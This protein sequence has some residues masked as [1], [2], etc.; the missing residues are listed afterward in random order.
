MVQAERTD[1]LV[2]NNVELI[3]GRTESGAL[4]LSRDRAGDSAEMWLRR[5][6]DSTDRQSAHARRRWQC[7]ARH[8]A[9]E[10]SHDWRIVLL[11]RGKPRPMDCTVRTILGAPKPWM[12]PAERD[13][14]LIDAGLLARNSALA[15]TLDADQPPRI[16]FAEPTQL[17]SQ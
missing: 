4:W 12:R 2:S 9:G 15:I 6:G 8:C 16:D 1:I 13:C 14:V 10:T 5:D 11:R 17:R 7:D 3:G